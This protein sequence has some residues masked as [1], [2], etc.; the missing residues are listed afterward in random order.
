V[1]FHVVIKGLTAGAHLRGSPLDSF[2]NSA[3]RLI[4]E[5]VRDEESDLGLD[6]QP[7]SHFDLYHSAMKECSSNTACIDTFVDL[8][9]KGCSATFALDIAGAPA[10]AR[11]FVRTLST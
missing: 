11:K 2:E 8:L 1:G 9:R 3:A 6:G 10:G 7:V 4:N 5:I